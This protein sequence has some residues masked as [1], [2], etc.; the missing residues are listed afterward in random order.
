MRNNGKIVLFDQTRLQQHFELIE[1][2]DVERNATAIRWLE[3]YA[4]QNGKRVHGFTGETC[5]R[6]Q[7]ARLN[8]WELSQVGV[9]YTLITDNISS[10]VMHQQKAGLV[11]IGV[12]RMAAN[13][14]TAAKIGV[15]G[16]AVQAQHFTSPFTLF[17]PHRL[18][19]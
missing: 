5:P 4:H 19:I 14:D 16:L 6:L 1:T 9:P 2:D 18:S 12:D 15:Y 13:G 11:M 10:W 8:A 17:R 7:G 3:I